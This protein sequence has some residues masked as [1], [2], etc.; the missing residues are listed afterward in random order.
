MDVPQ[1]FLNA[2]V[3]EEVY[4][5]LPEGYRTG[6]EHMVCKLKKAL[7]GLKQAPRNWYLLIS[8]FVVEEL[9]YKATISDPCLFFKRSR[10]GRL[11][12]LFLFVDDFQSSFHREDQGEWNESKAKL[13]ARFRTK[14]LGAST[15]ILGMR[16]TRDRKA[17]TITLDQEL[18]V[19]KALERYGLLECKVASTPGVPG[20]AAAVTAATSSA[21]VPAANAA[22]ANANLERSQESADKQLFQEMVGTLMYSAVS[23]RP[24]IAHAVQVLA[25]SMQAPTEQHMQAAKR[26]FRYLAGSKDIGLI[27]GSRN[28]DSVADSRGRALLT[29]DVCAY[30][31]ADWANGKADRV[32]PSRGGWPSSTVTP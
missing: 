10:S 9:G 24:D 1:A 20:V 15:W 31:D 32:G 3:D 8:K 29:V 18:Y 19:T 25:R 21:G 12:L 30:A 22:E 2:D 23:C 17:R 4:M 16:I 11:L 7:Y 27:F 13:V 6:R 5:E 28:G 26:V 14:D